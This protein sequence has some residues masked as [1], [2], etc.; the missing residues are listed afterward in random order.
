METDRRLQAE[1]LP[2]PGV[3]EMLDALDDPRCICSNSRPERL[4]CR[5]TKAGLWDRFRPYVFSA[6]AAWA[7]A[8]SRPPTSSCTRQRCFET[9]PADAIVVEDSVAGVTG[10]VA[11][12]MR[13]IGF[14]G[15][16]HTWP[17]HGEALM[18]AG[19]LTVIRR[20]MEVP[21]TVEAL[22]EWQPEAI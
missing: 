17:G 11:A 14:T 6:Q 9:D 22:R 10:G 5:L 15:A 3:Q 20:L 18:E 4:Q 1:V 13:V 2:I 7:A 12:G 8:A 16:S 21:A 19:A